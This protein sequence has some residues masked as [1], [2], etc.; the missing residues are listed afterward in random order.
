VVGRDEKGLLEAVRSLT[1]GRLTLAGSSLSVGSAGTI[2]KRRPLD[3]PKWLTT[4][5]KIREAISSSQKGWKIQRILQRPSTMVMYLPP[6]LYRS[7]TE[8]IPFEMAFE[9][10]NNTR[11]LHRMDA[12]INGKVFQ[13]EQF[14]VPPPIM[15]RMV[16][17]R[18]TFKIPTWHLTGRD[19]LAVRFTFTDKKTEL[20]TTAEVKDTIKVDPGSTIDLTQQQRFAELPDLSYLAYTGFPFSTMADLSETV[21]LLPAK[22]DQYEIEGMLMTLDISATRQAS[23]NCSDSRFGS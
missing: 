13:T 16:R 4:E 15:G 17:H 3:A 12:L 10:S 22:P 7:E 20:C 18:L 9:S 23:C 2:A 5:K 11:Y 6:N 1:L 21:V 8:W 14:D 19:T